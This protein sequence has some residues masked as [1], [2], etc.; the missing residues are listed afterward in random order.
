MAGFDAKFE[1]IDAKFRVVIQPMD[2]K[3]EGK[4]ER[5]SELDPLLHRIT[6]QR[7]YNFLLMAMIAGHAPGESGDHE[8]AYDLYPVRM[9]AYFSDFRPR[10]GGYTRDRRTQRFAA[11]AWP[12]R[13]SA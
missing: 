11:C 10:I 8:S 13:C 7:R 5:S 9:N 2:S 12:A 3:F 1:G 6:T 4:F